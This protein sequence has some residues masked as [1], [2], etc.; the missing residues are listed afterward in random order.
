MFTNQK[1]VRMFRRWVFVGLG[2][3]CVVLGIIGIFLPLMPTTVFLL[4]A[5]WFFAH[6][7]PKSREW[8]LNH[9]ILGKSIGNYIKHKGITRK[10][11]L[12]A[13]GMLWT[14]LAISM[15]FSWN[16]WYVPVLLTIIGIGV[17]AHLCLLNTLPEGPNSPS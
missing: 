1:V 13:L 12:K 6:S 5:A 11:R 10:T 3:L 15:Y 8:L 2:F 4:L 7:S 17:S 9:P 16:I 14:T